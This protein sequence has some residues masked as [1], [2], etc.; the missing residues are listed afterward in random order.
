[1]KYTPIFRFSNNSFKIYVYGYVTHYS[2]NEYRG[3]RIET[4][5]AVYWKAVVISVHLFT[6]QR[7]ALRS[8]V[9]VATGV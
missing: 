7:P 6:P 3:T 9:E 8:G 2:M 5:I 4:D 1:V